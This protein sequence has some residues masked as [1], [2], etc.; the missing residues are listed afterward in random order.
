[1]C[2]KKKY[3]HQYLLNTVEVEMNNELFLEYLNSKILKDK[4]RDSWD[5]WLIWKN[6]P[7]RE[8]QI[9]IF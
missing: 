9:I 8:L 5:G 4:I 3:T 2:N 1:M 6:I 7:S